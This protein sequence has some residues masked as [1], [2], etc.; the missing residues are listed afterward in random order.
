[1]FD[2]VV[3]EAVLPTRYPAHLPRVFYTSDMSNTGLIHT[4]PANGMIV[5]T[6]NTGD[7]IEA[8]HDP[9]FN[10]TISVNQIEYVEGRR[11]RFDFKMFFTG[12]R[13]VSVENVGERI[14]SMYNEDGSVDYSINLNPN[15]QLRFMEYYE[16]EVECAALN[17]R[18]HSKVLAPNQERAREMARDALVNALNLRINHQ[19][20][21]AGA[22]YTYSEFVNPE[23][24]GPRDEKRLKQE[25]VNGFIYSVSFPTEERSINHSWHLI[26][27]KL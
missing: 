15:E 24:R 17:V 26:D 20:H 6:K 1:M 2:T 12:G 13:L 16:V 8:G 27:T 5:V 19:N 18:S 14:R 3:V 22:T 25:Y 10:L 23:R 4:V 11:V 9:E 7:C 21:R